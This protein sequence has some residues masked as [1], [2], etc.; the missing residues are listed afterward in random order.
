MHR[1]FIGIGQFS[2][3][4]RWFMV[5]AWVIVTFFSVRAFPGLNSISQSGNSGFLPDSTPSIQASKLAATFQSA[6][7]ASVTLIAARNDGPLTAADQTTIDQVETAIGTVSH[8]THVRDLGVSR[9]DA[10]RQAS[11]QTDLS[12]SNTSPASTH[13]VNDIRAKLSSASAQSGLE[14]HLTGSLAQ[15]VDNN[16]NSKATNNNTTKFTI[17]FIII[18]LLVIFR[19]PLAPLITLIPAGLVLALSG[20]VI[21]GAA[22]RLNVS[23]SGITQ[24][25]LIVL[26]LGAGTD[27]A[28]FLIYR[29]R[30]E[31]WRGLTPHDAVAK[32]VSTV[33]ETITFS[34]FTV[35]VALLSLVLAQ[36]GLYQSLGPS[37]AIGIFLM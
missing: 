31:L 4:F 20:P 10:A 36:F 29:V 14:M 30:E 12:R 3:R 37:L 34:A 22:N 27:Y 1:F 15:A 24:V 13:L 21:T 11:I 32:A 5:A 6:G 28:L 8:V 35:I 19:A 16:A 33:G 18:L 25:I 23:V 17:L 26:V 7:N 2:V 9:D